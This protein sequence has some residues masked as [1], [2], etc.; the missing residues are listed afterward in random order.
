MPDNREN[1]AA[2]W[3]EAAAGY[4]SYF[5]PRFWAWN[6]EALRAMTEEALPPGAVLVPCCGPGHELAALS[7][8]LPGRELVGVDLSAEMVARAGARAGSEREGRR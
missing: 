1:L 7:Q 2:A 8:R 5:V 4:E 3:D 6:E